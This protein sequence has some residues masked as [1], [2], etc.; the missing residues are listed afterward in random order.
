MIKEENAKDEKRNLRI[1][2]ESVYAVAQSG[3]PNN[4]YKMKLKLKDSTKLYRMMHIWNHRNTSCVFL[5]NIVFW[6]RND[7]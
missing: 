3:M 4:G 2:T 5:A 1:I 7:F 6:V